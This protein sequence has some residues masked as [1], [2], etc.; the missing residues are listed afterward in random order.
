M[1]DNSVC[2][3]MCVCVPLETVQEDDNAAVFQQTHS[4]SV[5][6][7]A[8]PGLHAASRYTPNTFRPAPEAVFLTN[9][10]IIIITNLKSS[11]KIIIKDKK[12]CNIV[13]PMHLSCE[14]P[15]G[16]FCR[17]QMLR[18]LLILQSILSIQTSTNEWECYF[19][20]ES[21]QFFWVQTL[22][23]L[24]FFCKSTTFESKCVISSCWRVA[25]SV[26]LL[27][28]SAMVEIC[29][30]DCPGKHRVEWSTRSECFIQKLHTVEFRQNY[31]FM[32]N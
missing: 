30:L 2:V 5:G 10:C 15:L 7:S 24:A 21:E 25:S 23:V 16:V 14:L 19:S 18:E 28:S 11:N 4:C 17:H 32:R 12:R 1:Q 29:R 3:H 27:S 13:D 26:F 31:I 22:T 9:S 8:L 20:F 6:F